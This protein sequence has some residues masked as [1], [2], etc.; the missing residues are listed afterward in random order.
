MLHSRLKVDSKLVKVPRAHYTINYRF[1]GKGDT[2]AHFF[3]RFG[4]RVFKQRTVCIWGGMRYLNLHRIDKCVFKLIWTMYRHQEV[5]ITWRHAFK[6]LP[7]SG[8]KTKHSCDHT[9][10]QTS[11]GRSTNFAL[12]RPLRYRHYWLRS[13]NCLKISLYLFFVTSAD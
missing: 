1:F 10:P 12:L 4:M 7:L 8:I 11:V 2:R 6:N 5:H 13:N 9:Q 3:A